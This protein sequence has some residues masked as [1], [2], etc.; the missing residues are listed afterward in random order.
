[1][2]PPYITKEPV[3][4]LQDAAKAALDKKLPPNPEPEP[5]ATEEGEE[6]D[7]LESMAT[8]LENITF[9]LSKLDRH[10]FAA[11]YLKMAELKEQAFDDGVYQAIY[12]PTI[13]PEDLYP[14][15][16]AEKEKAEKEQEEAVKAALSNAEPQA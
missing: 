8:S 9:F 1:M 12:D 16:K 7:F 5:E 2:N 13:A 4:S 3:M 14:H 6:V 10:L 15:L 11:N